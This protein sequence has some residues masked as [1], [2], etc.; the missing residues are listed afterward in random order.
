VTD[1]PI[2]LTAGMQRWQFEHGRPVVEAVIEAITNAGSMAE[3][4][5][6]LGL[7]R[8]TLYDWTDHM[9]I[10]PVRVPIPRTILVIEEP[11]AARLE[12]AG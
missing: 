1:R 9:G 11:G 5:R 4:A 7:N 6:T 12:A 8:R 10:K 2:I 3:A